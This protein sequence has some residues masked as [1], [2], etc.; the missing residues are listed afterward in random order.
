MGFANSAAAHASRPYAWPPPWPDLVWVGKTEEKA[1]TS[2]SPVTWCARR[3]HQPVRRSVVVSND[4]DLV[5]PIAPSA[6]RSGAKV[7]SRS[8]NVVRRDGGKGLLT[9]VAAQTFHSRDERTVFLDDSRRSGLFF[10]G[11]WIDDAQILCL[12]G[13]QRL[14][15]FRR[16]GIASVED[17]LVRCAICARP[18]S[19]ECLPFDLPDHELQSNWPVAFR[20]R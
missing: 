12:S 10:S 19:W 20:W 2:T 7:A 3:F 9:S 18:F 8:V 14:I 15:L 4:T 16:G 13:A 17:V 11:F 5:E 1:V 6:G